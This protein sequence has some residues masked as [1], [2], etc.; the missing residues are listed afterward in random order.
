MG[1]VRRRCQHA[2]HM[3]GQGAEDVGDAGA[4]HVA[5]Q[6][7]TLPG[8]GGGEDEAGPTGQ[9][10]RPWGQGNQEQRV[11]TEALKRPGGIKPQ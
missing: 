6:V 4:G 10:T 2:L 3:V 9:N 7:H 11:V 1:R 5:V 8:E